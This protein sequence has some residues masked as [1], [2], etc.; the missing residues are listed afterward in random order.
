MK[1]E[2]IAILRMRWQRFSNYS[3]QAVQEKIKAGENA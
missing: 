1:P 2:L 3:R